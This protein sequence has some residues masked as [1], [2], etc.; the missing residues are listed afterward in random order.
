ML[1]TFARRLSGLEPLL[2]FRLKAGHRRSR[3]WKQ[4]RA[5]VP[6]SAGSLRGPSGP[7][8][9]RLRRCAALPALVLAT[10]LHASAAT[11]ATAPLVLDGVAAE[12]GE[13]RVTI[14]ETMLLAR[15]MAAARQIPLAEQAGQLRALYGEALDHLVARQ[16]VLQAYR[17][18]ENKLPAWV[19]DRRVDAFIDEQFGGD[20]SLLV[21]MLNKQRVG[22]DT[23]RQRMEEELV[24]STMRQQFVEQNVTVPAAD[25]RAYYATNRSEFALD[26]PVRVGMILIAK[27]ADETDE[28]VSNR[29]STVWGQLK[30]GQDFRAVAKRESAEAHAKEGGDWGYVEPEDVFR[31]EIADALAKLDKG[32][33]SPPIPTESGIYIVTRLNDC[34]GGILPLAEAWPVIEARLRKAETERRFAA[35]IDSLKRRTTV[36]LHSLP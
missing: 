8:G 6:A 26:G 21:S 16:L 20:R 27:Q 34:P 22:F 18:G 1:G 33:V 7:D 28:A 10:A 36:R 29:A 35:W 32:A 2:S 3:A 17:S 30:D 23:W 5:G 15:E 14:A 25:V 13:A 12:V 11:N 19:V 4:R 31:A 24:I 9:D